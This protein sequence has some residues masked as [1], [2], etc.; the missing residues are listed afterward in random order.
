MKNTPAIAFIDLENSPVL[1]FVW[2]A[3][4]TNILWKERD[5]YLMSYSVKW[6]RGKHI[7]LAL[8][9]FPL[10]KKEKHNDRELVKSL[11]HVF[12][13]ADVLIA[14]N[15]IDFDEKKAKTRFIAHGLPP[16][17]PYKSIDTLKEARKIG[18]ATSNKLDDLCQDL[19]LGKKL[20]HTGKNLWRDCINGDLK[21]WKLMKR[22]NAHDVYLLEKLYYYLRPWMKSHPDLRLYTRKVGCPVCGSQDVQKRGKEHLLVYD[23]QRY[24]C[25]T[26]GKNYLGEK[27]K[28]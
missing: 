25:S 9:D 27:I 28:R 3:Y 13:K 26:C 5:W 12:D 21:A 14:H 2:E 18:K 8:P 10:Y 6:H 20:P 22:Y 7:T 1:A 4:E 19:K 15:G 11:W 17:S 16:P 23:K 24:S